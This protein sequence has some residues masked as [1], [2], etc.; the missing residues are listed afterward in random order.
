MLM[1]DKGYPYICVTVG[2]DYPRVMMSRI[3][4]RDR[5]LYFGPYTSA[6][7]VK[8]TLELLQKLFR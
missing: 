1:D 3:I 6:Y 2:E 7:A 4:R 8:E 5:S